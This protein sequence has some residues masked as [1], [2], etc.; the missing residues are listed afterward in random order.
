MEPKC[1]S[2]EIISP[3]TWKRRR[4]GSHKGRIIIGVGAS[5]PKKSNVAFIC[6]TIG[7]RPCEWRIVTDG[8][9]YI[10]LKHTLSWSSLSAYLVHIPAIHL[11]IR[12]TNGDKALIQEAIRKLPI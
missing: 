5:D 6:D 3:C 11:A 10:R 7:Y 4:H 1:K 9:R 2:I 12:L 8:R